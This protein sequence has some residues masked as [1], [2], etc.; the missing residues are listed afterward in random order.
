MPVYVLACQQAF[1]HILCGDACMVFARHPQGIVTAH[2]MVANEDIFYS[3]SDGVP[4]VQRA[5]HIRRRHADDEGGFGRI[6]A[7]F[8]VATF[9]PEAIPLAFDGLWVICFW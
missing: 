8:E 7:R 2:T 9:F 4:Q 1:N 6:T 3:G 5:G